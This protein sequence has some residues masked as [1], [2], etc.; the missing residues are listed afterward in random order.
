M[1]NP[2]KK[3]SK[4]N[5]QREFGNR[6][7]CNSVYQALIRA[8]LSASEYKICLFVIDKTWGFNKVFDTISAAQFQEAADLSERMV[9]KVVQDLKKRRI[10]YFEPSKRVHRGSP[11]NQ[12]LFNKHYDTWFRK[13]GKE[14]WIT[15]DKGAISCTKRVQFHVNKG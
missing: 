4:I 7:I 2:W 6:Q 3:L 8:D 1:N 12:Y 15:D 5:P 14:L 10:I 11:F 9:R 13:D